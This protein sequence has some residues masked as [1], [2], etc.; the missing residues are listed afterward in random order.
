MNK[1]EPKSFGANIETLDFSDNDLTDKHGLYIVALIKSQ[2]V[3][4]D[5]ELFTSSLRREVAENH[6]QARKDQLNA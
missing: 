2:S 6:L 1:N 3:K 4:R 5:N